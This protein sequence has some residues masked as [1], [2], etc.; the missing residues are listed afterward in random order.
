MADDGVYYFD[1]EPGGGMIGTVALRKVSKNGGESVILDHG[2][3]GWVKYL[4]VDETQVYFTDISNV[5]ALEK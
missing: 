4:A 2:Q 1:N 5:Y 3:P